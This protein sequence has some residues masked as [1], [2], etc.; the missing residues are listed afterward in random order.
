MLWNIVLA[1]L[2]LAV[3]AAYVCRVDHTLWT[4]EPVLHAINAAGGISATWVLVMAG[5]GTAAA[6]EVVI[7]VA[8]TVALLVTYRLVPKPP[9]AKPVPSAPADH[10]RRKLQAEELRRVAGGADKR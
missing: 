1:A 4:R 8:A 3:A 5:Q 10:T 7:L 9:K 2:A 6:G